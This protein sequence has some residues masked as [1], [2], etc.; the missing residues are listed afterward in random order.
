VFRVIFLIPYFKEEFPLSYYTGIFSGFIEPCVAEIER[1]VNGNF[2]KIENVEK[3]AQAEDKAA[4]A[5]RCE[6]YYFSYYSKRISEQKKKLE[7]QAFPLCCF[8]NERF[9]Y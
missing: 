3:E 7:K 5:Q 8:G 1:N 6:L 2:D 9:A 4:A